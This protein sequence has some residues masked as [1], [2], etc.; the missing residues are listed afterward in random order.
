MAVESTEVKVNNKERGGSAQN[1][2]VLKYGPDVLNEIAGLSKTKRLYSAILVD[3]TICGYLFPAETLIEAGHLAEQLLEVQGALIFLTTKKATAVVRESLTST[4]TLHCFDNHSEL[5]DYSPTLT[6]FIQTALGHTTE[7]IEE[8]TDLSHQVLMS[9]VPVLTTNGLNQKM[10]MEKHHRRNMLLAVIDNYTPVVT[11]AGKMVSQSR[12]SESEFFERLK[13]LE[14]EKLIFPVFMKIQFLVNCFKNRTAFT[15]KE[16]LLA[17][18]LINRNQLDELMMELNSTPLKQRVSLGALA[19]RKGLINS[20]QLEIALQDQAFYGQ[21]EEN[22]DIKL[23][24][25]SGEESKVQSLVGHLGSTDPSNLLQNLATNRETGV[26]S[27]EYRDMQF[28]ALFEVGK[29]THAKL[30]KIMGNPS[31]IG[32]CIGLEAGH[33]CFHPA[34]TAG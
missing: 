30:G 13:E 5:Y 26:L 1:I 33:F 9:T 10:A 25:V 29:I 15:L 3:A 4:M 22:E 20:R 8:S 6:K 21:T 19:V 2:I 16:L 23:G 24:S 18:E 32:V 14:H 7:F 28:R 11:L 12:L 17:A 27:V 34:H 31:V